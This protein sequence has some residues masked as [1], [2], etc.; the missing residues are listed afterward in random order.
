M[1]ES[2]L[3]MLSYKR[4]VIL[5]EKST[6]EK[7]AINIMTELQHVMASEKDLT[8]IGA[9]AFLCE[10]IIPEEREQRD[11][12]TFRD[13]NTINKLVP[14]DNETR[15]RGNDRNNLENMFHSLPGV[16]RGSESRHES[17]TSRRSSLENTEVSHAM[18]AS[19][20]LWRKR[21][22]RHDAND[23]DFRT[24]L[25]GHVGLGHP[26]KHTHQQTVEFALPKMSCHGGLTPNKR[27][28]TKRC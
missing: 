16:G 19:A 28:R 2:I 12:Q 18:L 8:V 9:E 22:G 23:V 24:G 15:D 5:E 11:D 20:E 6:I 14:N 13:S 26:H 21:N 1:V 17:S 27:G 10:N 7:D 3:Y 25:S 4:R